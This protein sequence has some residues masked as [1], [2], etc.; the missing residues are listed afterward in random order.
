[1]L[2]SAILRRHTLAAHLHLRIALPEPWI[3][4]CHMMSLTMLNYVELCWIKNVCCTD[5]TLSHSE[6]WKILKVGEFALDPGYPGYPTFFDHRPAFTADQVDDLLRSCLSCLRFQWIANLNKDNKDPEDASGNLNLNAFQSLESLEPLE[7]FMFFFSQHFGK[8][9]GFITKA[10]ALQALRKYC[11]LLNQR[12]AGCG[13]QLLPHLHRAVA[14]G[15]I[16]WHPVASGHG[17]VEKCSKNIT[18]LTRSDKAT[19][20]IQILPHLAERLGS[21]EHIEL[22]ELSVPT[23]A[24][25]HESVKPWL[26]T[27]NA[28]RTTS[29]IFLQRFLPNFCTTKLLCRPNQWQLRFLPALH[30]SDQQGSHAHASPIGVLYDSS[31]PGVPKCNILRC[32]KHDGCSM[33]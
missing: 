29:Y 18:M 6:S 26:P 31:Q 20:I 9:T 7:P 1:M 30:V 21:I 25:Y 28:Q 12:W 14:S 32:G 8:Q 3:H 24:S 11:A 17:D 22:P 27:I 15:G 33:M 2:K 10:Q 16:R 13:L 23:I 4:W 5:P 19:Q